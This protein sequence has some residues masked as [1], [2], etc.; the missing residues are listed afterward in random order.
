MTLSSFLTL[1]RNKVGRAHL[2]LEFK[3]A[4]S[5]SWQGKQ[6]EG[7][8]RCLSCFIHDK[9]SRELEGSDTRL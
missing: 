1:R 4:Y 9:G 2:G 6:D 5:P 8:V 3:V 7:H